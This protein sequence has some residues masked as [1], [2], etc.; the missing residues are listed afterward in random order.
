MRK[1]LLAAAMA[2]AMMVPGYSQAEGVDFDAMTATERAAFGEAVRSYL[3]ENPE[4]IFEAIQIL[5][6]RRALAETSAEREVLET[7]AEAIYNDGYS[8][9]GGNP[10]GDV[11]IVEFVDY[12][13]G[14]CKRAHPDMAEL[15][16]R[17]PNVRLITKDFPILGPDSVR[18]GK[19]ALAAMAVDPSKFKAL[20]DALM[21]HEGSLT[22]QVAYRIAGESGYDIAAL[23]EKAASAEIDDR[24][25]QNYELARAL[26]LQGTPAF[27]VGSQVI[28]GYLPVED[29]LAA[30]ESARAQN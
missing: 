24:L 28:R 18:A 27:I 25:N 17:D 11:T 23:K 30:V 2:V 5:E 21:G 3:L 7:F 9:V 6:E 8:H 16:D 4:V 13:C 19:M 26:N 10:D 14:F 22:E 12:R 1:P 29:M 15:L 20:N